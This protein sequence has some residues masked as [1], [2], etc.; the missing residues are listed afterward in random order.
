MC[1]KLIQ[2]SFVLVLCLMDSVSL[3]SAATVAYWRFDDVGDTGID[4]PPGTVAAGHPLPDSDSW[5]LWRKAAHDHSGN[6][7]HLMTWEYPGAGHVWSSDVP[8]SMIPLT[9]AANVLSI[10]NS[11]NWPAAQTWSSHSAPSGIDIQG[12]TPGAFTIEVSFKLNQLPTPGDTYLSH[13]SLIGRDGTGLVTGDPGLSPLNFGTWPGNTLLVRFADVA[14]YNHVAETGPDTIATDR[15]YNVAAVSDGSTLSLYLDGTLVAQTDLGA[16]GSPNTAMASGIDSNGGGWEGGNWSISRGHRNAE[17][18]D[19]VFGYIDEVRVSDTALSPSEFL[20]MPLFSHSPYPK[21]DATDVPRDV[22]LSWTPGVYAQAHDVYFGSAFDD[23]N[24]ATLNAPL[25]VLVSQEQDASTFVPE[26]V[27]DFDQTYYWRVDDINRASGEVTVGEVWRLT[28][29]PFSYAI[30]TGITA[31]A[32]SSHAANMGP[33]KTIDRSGLNDLDQHSVDGPDMWLSSAGVAPI[34]I[35]YEFDQ[36]HKLDQM[37]VWNSNQIIEAFMGLGAKDVTIETSLGGIDWIQLEDATQFAQA[38]GSPMYTAN[39][40]VDFEGSLAKYVRLTVNSG[41]G[42]MPQNGISEVRFFSIPTQAR[43]PIPTSGDMVQNIDVVLSW[44]AGRG[45]AVHEVYWGTDS[46]DLALIGTTPS[47][48]YDLSAAGIE[49]GRT[50]YWQINEVN[51][52]AT[53]SVY[54]GEIWSFTTPDY[55]AVD[56]F[57]LYNDD[58]NRIFFAWHDGWGHNGGESIDDCDIPPFS[59]NG[60]G[61]LVGNDQAPFAERSIVHSGRQSMPLGYDGAGSEAQREFTVPQ[62]WTKGGTQTLVLYFAGNAADNDAGDVYVKINGENKVVSTSAT[63]LQ[64]PVWSLGRVDLAS[65]STDLS[66]VRTLAVG[67]D[68]SGTGTVYV[69]DIRLYRVAPVSL[70]PIDPGTEGLVAHYPLDNNLQDSTGNGYDGTSSLLTAAYTDGPHGLGRALTLSGDEFEEDFV[71]LPIGGLLQTL[72]DSTFAIWADFSNA[73]GAWQR[74]FDFGSGQHTNMFLTP[75]TGT[76]GALRFAIRVDNSPESQLNSPRTLPSG[77]Q[78]V[79]VVF[80][81]TDMSMQ[82]YINGALV[83]DR[84]TAFVPAD[85]GNT[86]QNWLGKSQ[87]PDALYT[88]SLDEFRIY[89]RALPLEEIRY[90]AGDR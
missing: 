40:T 5:A 8:A 29:E 42:M 9:G 21:N 80:N 11:G 53:P 2:L 38:T 19:R 81:S 76:A 24:I 46:G 32:S 86:T 26:E 1:S 49:Y 37:W 58:C 82:L 84:P 6:G 59:G 57:E 52:T 47:S 34:W 74:I 41:Y 69:D 35:Q 25:G 48:N 77:W 17:H 73:S 33:E 67:V 3:V 7:N 62:D 63:A 89:D 39:T 60:T 20:F 56:D 16:S 68:S 71:Q 30:A 64:S 15:W 75:R 79:A 51:E 36:V 50:Y 72:T 27:L 13:L 23:V 4:I 18:T 45:A 78:H 87:W 12:L 31:T 54:V 28:V 61:S 88:G 43:E 66:S 65:V 55:L 10:V 83:D 22:V 85:L 90:L 44:R 70:L 14:G